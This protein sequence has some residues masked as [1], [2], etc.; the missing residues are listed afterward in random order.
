MGDRHRIKFLIDKKI[1]PDPL[2]KF[3]SLS[4]CLKLFLNKTI[5]YDLKCFLITN[6][7]TRVLLDTVSTFD[8]PL[9]SLRRMIDFSML[10]LIGRVCPI[11]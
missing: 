8:L 10:S 5:F 6:L 11:E 7:L 1:G 2:E 9:R 4:F 3:Q